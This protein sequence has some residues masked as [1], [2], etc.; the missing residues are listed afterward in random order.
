ML[1]YKSLW[2]ELDNLD[3]DVLLEMANLRGKDV[4]IED[5]DFSLF[6]SRK[7]PNHGCRVKICWNRE[8]MTHDTGNLEIH[9]DYKYK[10]DA[11]CK[12]KPDAVELSTARYFVKKYKVLFAAVW[13]EKL[14]PT[15]VIDYFRERLTWNELLRCFINVSQTDFTRIQNCK[16][17]KELEDCVR[18]YKIYNMN[19]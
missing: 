14:D 3:E 8:K 9:G 13:E 5:I 1:N 19:D 17:R 15:D 7:Y 12:Y 2:E 16:T 6:F 18:M 10:H 4:K 11:S